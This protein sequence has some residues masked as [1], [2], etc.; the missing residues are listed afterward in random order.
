M[1]AA[2]EVL[3]LSFLHMLQ[4]A[5]EEDYEEI[6]ETSSQDEQEAAAAAAAAASQEAIDARK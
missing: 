1:S 3:G 4:V 2:A 6:A 5:C